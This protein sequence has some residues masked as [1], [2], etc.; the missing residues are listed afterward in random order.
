[1]TSFT[2]SPILKKAIK[3]EYLTFYEA[4]RELAEN[5]RKITRVEWG[6][7]M[8]YGFL[9]I[10]GYLSIYTQGAEHRWLVNDGDILAQDWYLLPKAD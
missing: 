9:S 5:K 7:K 3:T 1:M 6:S 8:E 4:L 2:T 10:D